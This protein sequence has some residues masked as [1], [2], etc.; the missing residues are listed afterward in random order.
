MGTWRRA[1]ADESLDDRWLDRIRHEMRWI[2][3]AAVLTW[4]VSIALLAMVLGLLLAQGSA[5][6]TD[7]AA[8]LHPAFGSH[9]GAVWGALFAPSG[10]SI[11]SA[12]MDGSVRVWDSLSGWILTTIP[13]EPGMGRSLAVSPDGKSL[14][15]GGGGTIVAI[16]DAQSGERRWTI[17]T[18]G[19][20][21]NSLAFSPDGKTLAVTGGPGRTVEL[22]DTGTQ[23]L[24]RTLRDSGSVPKRLDFAPDGRTL[25]VAGDDGSVTVWDAKDGRQLTQFGAHDEAIIALA[26]SPDGRVLATGASLDPVARLWEAATGRPL[27]TLEGHKAGLTS[28]A[29]APGGTSIATASGDGTIMLWDTEQSRRLG[30]LR[31]HTGWVWS[32]AFAPDGLSLVSG[33]ADSTLR[34]WRVNDILSPAATAET[35]S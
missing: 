33:G 31:G 22:W 4:G 30:T 17:N 3:K 23:A 24:W 9:D 10:Q 34:L 6:T 25:A 29:F 16:H 7:G 14:A 19:R 12:S 20:A 32:V 27:A 28:L 21:A 8:E 26:Y 5:E 2:I 11:A 35:G 18:H 15:I 1:D 13:L